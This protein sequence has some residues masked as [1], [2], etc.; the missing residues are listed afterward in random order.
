[1]GNPK[2]L[3]S[4]QL[5]VGGQELGWERFEPGEI[6]KTSCRPRQLGLCSLNLDWLLGKSANGKG[7]IRMGQILRFVLK[8]KTSGAFQWWHEGSDIFVL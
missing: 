2:H 5:V 6:H 1:M 3:Q 7:S 8:I 4:Y